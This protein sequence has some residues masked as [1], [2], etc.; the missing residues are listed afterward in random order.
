MHV[1]N[2]KI[3]VTLNYLAFL[4]KTVSIVFLE[5]FVLLVFQ[6]HFIQNVCFLQ[7]PNIG[8][9]VQLLMLLNH[10]MRELEESSMS[11]V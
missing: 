8:D 5:Y 9:K 4:L 1:I 2:V 10:L 3:L 6:L 11:E 7:V